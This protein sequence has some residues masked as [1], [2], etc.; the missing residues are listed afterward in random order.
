M[1]ELPRIKSLLSGKNPIKKTTKGYRYRFL[2]IKRRHKDTKKFNGRGFCMF[3]GDYGYRACFEKLTY[4]FMGEKTFNAY[5]TQKTWFKIIKNRMYISNN[6]ANRQ[7]NGVR[8]AYKLISNNPSKIS[9][10]AGGRENK[11]Q[12]TL[13]V[14]LLKWAKKNGIKIKNK[15]YKYDFKNVCFFLCYPEF[16]YF[17]DFNSDFLKIINQSIPSIISSKFNGIKGLNHGLDRFCGFHGKKLKSLLKTSNFV[18]K[19]ATAKTVKNL[20]TNDDILALLENNIIFAD[21]KRT[22]YF[23]KNY[24]RDTIMNWLNPPNDNPTVRG[25][26]HHNLTLLKDA[27]DQYFKNHEDNP[28][29]KIVL[30]DSNN[31]EDI[32]NII[33]RNYRRIEQRKIVEA[34]EKIDYSEKLKEYSKFEF[35]AGDLEV[36]LPKTPQEIINYSSELNNC[37]TGY[38]HFHTKQGLIL[39]VKSENKTKYAVSI[40]FPNTLE[41]FYGNYNTKPDLNDYKLIV[42]YLRNN[43]MIDKSNMDY[44][45]FP[46]VATKSPILI[47][48][49]ADLA[50]W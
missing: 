38:T 18:S 37:L 22:R 44:I 48:D 28:D 17:L 45:L 50:Q 30:P 29:N 23:L 15:W 2:N 25:L 20:V 31:L 4:D 19:L 5:S 33:T 13:K 36:V 21:N 34:E 39:I 46:T 40:R 26:R 3:F 47:I 32:H 41:Q 24:G 43:G 49:N 16:E 11:A 42:D 6:S 7:I 14:F 8:Q 10:A 1:T 12:D 35:K 27:S 9:F